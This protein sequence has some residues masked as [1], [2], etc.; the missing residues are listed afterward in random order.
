MAPG[1]RSKGFLDP[2][3]CWKEWNNVEGSL[4]AVRKKFVQK[5]ILNEKTGKPPTNS[6]IEKAA[7]MW[8]LYNQKEARKDLEF[9]W[10]R[11]GRILTDDEWKK[12]LINAANLVFYQRPNR[13]SEFL[14]ENGL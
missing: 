13:L 9:S 1:L 14:S 3:T 2:K 4:G 5:G 6:G 12:F 10:Q 8:A 7:F 11:E